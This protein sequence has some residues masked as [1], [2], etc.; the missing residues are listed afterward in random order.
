MV[1]VPSS[2]SID[3]TMNSAVAKVVLLSSGLVS[4]PFWVSAEMF[5]CLSCEAKKLRKVMIPSS[6]V[7]LFAA[8]KC[9]ASP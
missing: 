1:S 9:G 3:G 7:K 6:D 5:S 4:C 2:S 8:S